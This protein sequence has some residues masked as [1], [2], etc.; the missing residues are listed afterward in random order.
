[1]QVKICIN[2]RLYSVHGEFIMNKSNID[3]QYLSAEK[4]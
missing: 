4:W 1:M 3:S 2:I